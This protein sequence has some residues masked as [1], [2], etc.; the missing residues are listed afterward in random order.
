M[1]ESQLVSKMLGFTA[2]KARRGAQL[3]SCMLFVFGLT[4]QACVLVSVQHRSFRQIAKGITENVFL[5]SNCDTIY[6]RSF[7]RALT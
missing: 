4:R 2:E 6:Y 7:V 5:L 3:L 1:E